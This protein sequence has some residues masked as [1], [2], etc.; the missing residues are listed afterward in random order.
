VLKKRMVVATA[1]TGLLLAVSLAAAMAPAAASGTLG[2]SHLSH[3]STSSRLGAMT[4]P[5]LP[6]NVKLVHAGTQAPTDAQC[7]AQIDTPCY[8]PQNIETAYGVNHLLNAGDNGKGQ[9]IVI[10]D[11]YGSP[12]IASD[13]ASFD[14]G[15]GLPNPPSFTIL[16]PLGTVPYDP[17]S[18]PDQV[19]WA[20]ETTLDVEWSHAMAP[21]ASIVLMTSPVDE[22]EG[23]QGLPQ[24]NELENYALDHHLGQIISQSWGATENT[25]FNASG[26]QV[27]NA[28]ENTY[29]RAAALGVTVF[30]SAGDSGTANVETDGSTIYPFPTVNFPASSPLVTA[31]GGTSLYADRMELCQ[32]RDR[33]RRQPAVQRTPVPGVPTA[34]RPDPAERSPGPAR[35]RLERR[36]EHRD[37]DLSVVLRS[38]P[39]RLLPDRRHQ[40]RITAVG[41]THR[42]PQPAG[43]APDRLPQPVP[44]R[45]RRGRNRLPRRHGRQQRHRRNPRLQRH[46]RLGRDHRLGYPRP[47]AVL[48][49][50]RLPRPWQSRHPLPLRARTH[51]ARPYS[52][53]SLDAVR[54]WAMGR[55]LIAYGAGHHGQIPFPPNSTQRLRQ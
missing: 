41:R 51:L 53:S 34:C 18:I 48:R 26:E 45:T 20:A 25:L 36:P 14:Q 39:G 27:I 4:S 5:S 8:S 37:P 10:I 16:S 19:S 52:A 9:T 46:P 13:L 40:R 22:T 6:L 15:F 50:P 24:F 23:V 32:Q 44:L 17:T 29:A 35:H 33:R 1:G 47:R 38:G 28:F 54:P 11:S 3:S 2:A 7:E 21:D 55:K 49:R 42:R 43:R 31:V 30:A 12:T